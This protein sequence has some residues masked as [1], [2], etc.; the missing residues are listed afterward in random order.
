M[1]YNQTYE[2]SIHGS[3]H[4]CQSAATPGRSTTSDSLPL[5]Q[6][7]IPL[8]SDSAQNRGAFIPHEVLNQLSNALQHLTSS[9][10]ANNTPTPGNAESTC[11]IEDGTPNDESS[12]TVEHSTLNVDYTDVLSE[13]LGQQPPGTSF[14]S[15]PKAVPTYIGRTVLPGA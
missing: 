9:M 4:R 8:P 10:Q 1:S 13:A 11:T 7:P 6:L 14:S 5:A 3:S 15:T 12:L 2:P